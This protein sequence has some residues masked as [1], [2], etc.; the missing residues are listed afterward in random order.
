MYTNEKIY[1]IELGEDLTLPDPPRKPRA[2]VSTGSSK[3]HP[4]QKARM[5]RPA[6]ESKPPSS[7]LQFATLV[8]LTYLL[9]PFSVHL[10]PDNRE[11]KALLFGGLISGMAGLG[12]FAGRGFILNLIDKGWPV[13]PWALIGA[14]VMVTAFSIW[15]RAALL[16]VRRDRQPRYQ[17]PALL[18]KPWAVGVAGLVAPGL[19]LLLAGCARRGAAVIWMGWT[20]VGA[21]MV[22]AGAPVIWA[23]NQAAEAGSMNPVFLETVFMLAAGILIAGLI[24]WIAQA[25]EGA[26]QMMGEPGV[27]H[28]MRGDWYAAALLVTML[29]LAVVWDPS[30]MAGHLDGGSVVLREMGF[31]LIPLKLSQGA[32]RLD[33]APSQYAI[34]AMELSEELGRSGEAARLRSE[35][36]GNLASYLALV[37]SENRGGPM[38]TGTVR[39][40]AQE[41]SVMEDLLG[42]AGPHGGNRPRYQAR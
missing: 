34:R 3:V 18:R 20:V 36:D 16:A 5:P 7:E 35:L 38:A 21:V 26:R 22:M 15:A 37:H 27:R 4:P 13:W 30:A 17:L 32:H 19:G 41:W 25:L 29:G 10:N 11:R 28:R 40:A 1:S 9:G 2:T 31:R 6:R 12:I 8:F 33:P 23:N 14:G 39:T 24:G 42:R